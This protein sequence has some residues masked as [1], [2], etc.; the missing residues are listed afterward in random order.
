MSSERQLLEE[1][2]GGRWW[3]EHVHRYKEAL[4]LI[5]QKDTVLDIAC[6]TGFGTD[7]I[8]E[9]ISG[10]AIGGD[11]S[12]EAIAECRQFWTKSN[13]EFR[14]LDG[15]ALDFPD[16]SFDAVVSFE[17]IEHTTSYRK[18]L[19]EFARVLKPSGKLIL[20]TPNAAITS[21][22][23]VIGNPFHTQEFR[24]EELK[25]LLKEVFP[26]IEVY[27]QRNKR[28]DIRS[29]KNAAG[30]LTEK[31]FLAFGINKLPYSIRSGMMKAFYGYPLY[32]EPIEFLLE[33]N[34]K[35]IQEECPVLFAVCKK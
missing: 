30:G 34:E 27:G 14:V 20:S 35:K 1:S 16:A 17:T 23:G 7:I 25:Q 12:A 26:S 33:S 11:I 21:P 9:H 4:K 5:G 13:I 18:M 15:T 10:K 29:F 3:G 6:G 28:Y 19:A 31:L 22:D 8:A 32:P 2:H 24:L